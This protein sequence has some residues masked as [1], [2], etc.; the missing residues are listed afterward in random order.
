MASAS[1]LNRQCL[2]T[3]SR[4]PI[5]APMATLSFRGRE[6]GL[7]AHDQEQID[8][9]DRPVRLANPDRPAGQGLGQKFR[10]IN[11][12]GTS[13]SQRDLALQERESLMHLASL[14]DHDSARIAWNRFVVKATA[15]LDSGLT[16]PPVIGSRSRDARP[17]SAP[18]SAAILRSRARSPAAST[19]TLIS[20]RTPNS[21]W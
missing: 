5:T 11:R 9:L 8:D 2:V 7:Q 21:A 4:A 12:I 17:G 15:D 3:Q 18:P 1:R 6:A 13:V 19:N 10:L 14:F 20:L 16:F